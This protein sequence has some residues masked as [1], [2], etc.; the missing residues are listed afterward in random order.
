MTKITK[1]FVVIASSLIMSVAAVAGELSVTGSAKAS[2][3]VNG[4]SSNNNDKGI[5]ISNEL[6]FSA[7]GELDNGYSWNYHM[8][9]DP[10]GGGTTDADDSSLTI[11]T[12]GMGTIGFFDSEGGLSTELGYGVGALGTGVDYANTMAS[13]GHTAMNWGLDVSSYPNIQYHMPSDVL[14]LGL[15][16]KVGYVPNAGDGY[17]NDFKNSGA[18]NTKGATG[19]SLTQIQLT[20]APVDG[21]KVGADYASAENETGVVDQELTGGNWYAQYAFGNF[22]V[23]YMQ[24]YK[25][26]G[27]ATYADGDGSSY[28]SY[29]YNAMGIEFAL[30]DAVSVSFDQTKNEAKDKGQIADGATTRTT[31]TVEME[32]DTMQIAYNIGGATVG[33]FHLDVSNSEFTS[34]KDATKTIASIAMEF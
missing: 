13:S 11:N 18:E 30:N 5:G 6:K 17:S 1:M 21:L 33:L 4:G 16:A 31:Q 20:A 25:E 8:E 14:P 12:N 3:L 27:K 23:G 19:D 29:E 10:N 32:A 7:S 2:Y 26:S 9:L 15:T 28:D 24:G 22:K 34:G